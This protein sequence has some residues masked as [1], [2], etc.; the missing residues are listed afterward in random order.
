MDSTPKRQ[1]GGRGRGRGA[2]TLTSDRID[3]TAP[4]SIV[5]EK[6]GGLTRFCELTAVPTS[7]AHSWA[8]VGLIPARR[9]AHILQVAATHSVP[10]TPPDFVPRAQAA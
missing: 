1:F 7:T 6:F 3:R 4:A 8:E 5:I 2:R 10:V 9:Q